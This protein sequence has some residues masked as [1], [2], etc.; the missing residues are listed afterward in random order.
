M[1]I[2]FGGLNMGATNC[3]FDFP[4]CQVFVVWPPERNDF[5]SSIFECVFRCSYLKNAKI[6]A[7]LKNLISRAEEILSQ[8]MRLRFEYHSAKAEFLIRMSDVRIFGDQFPYIWMMPEL[9][10][11]SCIRAGDTS[12]VSRRMDLTWPFC[13]KTRFEK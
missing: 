13:V 8:K 3:S 6:L 7:I 5:G 1:W 12:S 10:L 2:S 9:K 11:P 4:I